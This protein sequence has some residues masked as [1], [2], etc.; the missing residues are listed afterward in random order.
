MRKLPCFTDPRAKKEVAALC[1]QYEID[2][3]LL[4]GLSEIIQGHS[5]A[6]RKDG[7]IEQFNQVIDRFITRTQEEQ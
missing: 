2:Q 1:K 4:H 6:A 3:A 5:G 7:Y